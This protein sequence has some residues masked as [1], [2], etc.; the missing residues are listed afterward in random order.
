MNML[1]SSLKYRYDNVD[2][3]ERRHVIIN[4]TTSTCTRVTRLPDFPKRPKRSYFNNG[5]ARLEPGQL[6]TNA[7]KHGMVPSALQLV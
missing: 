6:H 3:P 5:V 1:F 4:L 7:N 2:I